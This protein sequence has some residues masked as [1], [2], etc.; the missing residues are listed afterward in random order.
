MRSKS[1]HFTFFTYL[2]KIKSLYERSFWSRDTQY[3]IY[4]SV[5]VLVL[6]ARTDE[7][8]AALRNAAALGKAI[9]TV[10]LGLLSSE[11]RSFGRRCLVFRCLF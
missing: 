4:Y 5:P 7:Q 11:M 6:R 2:L 10:T 1:L 8:T 9:L 3:I